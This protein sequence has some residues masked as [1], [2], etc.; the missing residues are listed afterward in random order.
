MILFLVTIFVL[1]LLVLAIYFRSKRRD[2][3]VF[4]HPNC[5]DGGGGEKVLWVAVDA[6]KDY[7]PEIGIYAENATNDEA[8]EKIKKCFNIQLPGNVSFINVGPANFIRPGNFPRFT[9]ILQAFSS[10]IYAVKCLLRF[11]PSVVID[12]TGAPFAIIVWKLLG[13]CKVVSYTHY[14][15]ISTDMLKNVENDVVSMNNQKVTKSSIVKNI[16]IYYYRVISFFYGCV[17]R[18]IDVSFVNS[19][20]TG[21]HIEQIFGKKPYILYPPCDVDEFSKFE[22]EGRE[23]GMIM[24]LGQFRPEKNYPM[25]IEILKRLHEKSKHFKL[26]IVGG[27][28]NPTDQKLF[29]Q[30]KNKVDEYGLTDYVT[31]IPNAPYDELKKCLSKSDI[32]LHTMKDEHFGICAVDYMSSGLIPVCNKSAGPLLDIVKDVDFLGLDIDEYVEKIENISK[33]DLQTKTELRRRFR[34]QSKAFDNLEFSKKFIEQMDS[35]IKNK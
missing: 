21:N 19:S 14:P 12:T 1:S 3:I 4:F 2:M 18:L 8:R 30:V 27:V 9:L 24:S 28:R 15:F 16:K 20:W 32:G 23:D 5:L 22:L 34:A 29:E 7:K 33:K 11:V 26:T 10:I 17:G 13:G 6:I 31:L 35:I 25:Q